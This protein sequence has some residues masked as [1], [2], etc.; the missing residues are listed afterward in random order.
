[1]SHRSLP[2]IFVVTIFH[3]LHQQL[4]HPRE[5]WAI[6]VSTTDNLVVVAHE[7]VAT[8]LPIC[9][10]L[11]GRWWKNKLVLFIFAAKRRNNERILLLL[12]FLK[13]N[14]KPRKVRCFCTGNRWTLVETQTLQRIHQFSEHVF[15]THHVMRVHIHSTVTGNRR[16][17]VSGFQRRRR[18]WRGRG[19]W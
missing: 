13:R 8:E 7:S 3:L 4:V 19:R 15:V 6:N 17:R 1:M 9:R 10:C 11:N 12:L 18:W 14:I 2:L 5:I 16:N